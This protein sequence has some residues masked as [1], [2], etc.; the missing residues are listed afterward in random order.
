MQHLRYLLFSLSLVLSC[1]HAQG[2]F[3][4]N[5]NNKLL[6]AVRIDKH[7]QEVKR[8]FKLYKQ[9]LEKQLKHQTDSL[10]QL[11][12]LPDTE[13]IRLVKD[14]I[15]LKEE[16]IHSHYPDSLTADT[17]DQELLN[18]WQAD[19][20]ALAEAELNKL[21]EQ[22]DY[23]L[24][25]LKKYSESINWEYLEDEYVAKQMQ[26]Y[27][28]DK[29]HIQNIPENKASNEE[30]A[31]RLM[32]LPDNLPFS[33]SD[34]NAKEVVSQQAARHLRKLKSK[35]VKVDDLHQPGAGA[36]P[37]PSASSSF[38][39]K[40][41]LGGQLNFTLDRQSS[42]SFMPTLGIQAGRFVT[43]N[44]DYSFDYVFTDSWI[45]L[46]KDA[47]A[48][49]RIGT[50]VDWTIKKGLFVRSKVEYLE[51]KKLDS[52][53]AYDFFVGIGKNY[54]IGKNL[55]SQLVLNYALQPQSDGK[56]LFFQFGIQQQG[57][58][59]LFSKKQ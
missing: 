17:L 49:P 25:S 29:G 9:Q 36:V 35:Y 31:K 45:Y 27:L 22:W 30:L 43:I 53:D 52:I 5:L 12:D 47:K 58:N 20:A 16:K 34:F 32:G 42:F 4:I 19:S 37:R 23:H 38:W 11:H 33:P 13:K 14:S 40:V 46:E 10:L 8:A 28:Q 2:Q 1:A 54:K 55:Q 26:K 41:N 44:L 3:S 50:F 48:T 59:N 6:P 56:R 7:E 51:G 57:L 15:L 39:D 18:K 21:Q 24:D